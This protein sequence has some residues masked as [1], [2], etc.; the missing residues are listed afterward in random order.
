[1]IFKIMMAESCSSSSFFLL[2]LT[3]LFSIYPFVSCH[4][5]GTNTGETW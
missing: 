5:S 4:L 1:M 2:L 3:L